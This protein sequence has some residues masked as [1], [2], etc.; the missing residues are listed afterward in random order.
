M[1]PNNNFDHP[2]LTP[3][4][5]I[6]ETQAEQDLKD[7]CETKKINDEME[8]LLKKKNDHE[9]NIKIR[10]TAKKQI[11]IQVIDNLSEQDRYISDI[12]CKISHMSYILT[13]LKSSKDIKNK[14]K[15][16]AE[17]IYTNNIVYYSGIEKDELTRITINNV[18][19]DMKE[20]R[21]KIPRTQVVGNILK[22]IFQEKNLISNVIDKNLQKLK[23]EML[24]ATAAFNCANKSN[25]IIINDISHSDASLA[26][27]EDALI[28]QQEKNQKLQK[29]ITEVKTK[30]AE[31][32]AILIKYN[33][34]II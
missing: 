34:A 23:E 7:K 22:Q 12:K 17:Q 33:K 10:E 29:D 25:I 30:L 5:S 1:E 16:N 4:N 24:N 8:L 20:I 9:E 18:V 6:I 15:Q 21:Y 11:Q 26:T 27:F 14:K 28:F 13:D 31:A 2:L 32:N 3:I 19:P